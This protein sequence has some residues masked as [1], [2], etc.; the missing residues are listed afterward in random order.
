MVP[1]FRDITTYAVRKD[2]PTCSRVSFHYVLVFSSSKRWRLYSADVKAASL[3]GEEFGPGERD[4]YIG[5]IQ[6]SDA[7]QPRLPLG[8]GQLARLKKGIFGL[9]DSPRRWYLRL[10]KSL[11]RLGWHHRSIIDSAMWLLWSD[12][13][14]LERVVISHVDDLLVGGSP[15]AKQLDELG[16]EL[17]FGSLESGSF[18]YCGKR[19][20]LR[21]D[22]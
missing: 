5:Q 14:E 22:D 10:H 8:D 19:I 20:H 2:A 11:T 1:G 18:M 17:G 7:D 16:K 15:R 3:K 13:G 12:S 9:A 21:G 6:T 4:L